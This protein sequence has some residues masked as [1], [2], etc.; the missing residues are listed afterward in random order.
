MTPVDDPDVVALLGQAVIWR[1]YGDEG[2]LVTLYVDDMAPAHRAR[3]LA[4]L[5]SRAHQYRDNAAD[6]ITLRERMGYLDHAEWIAA[7]RKLDRQP[8]EMWLEEQP[9]VRR[10]VQLTPRQPSPARGLLGRLRLRRSK[11]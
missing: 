4:H 8:A 7:L 9:L 10:L 11:R 3:V 6:R 2:Q 5:R 1:S